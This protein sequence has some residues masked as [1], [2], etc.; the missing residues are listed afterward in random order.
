MKE[1]LYVKLART[2][3]AYQRCVKEGK[4]FQ[5]VHWTTIQDIMS[6][7]PSGSGIDSGT[8]F[9]DTRSNGDK[10]VFYTHY[11]H[12]NE[13]GY[14]DGWTDH[15][16]TVKPSL[17]FGFDLSISGKNRNDIK[18]YLHDVYHYWLNGEVS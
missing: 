8:T 11:H 7:A 2:L 14:Y 6:T 15:T 1:K 12:M 3:D 10:L 5:F 9:D 13:G 18:D 4:D 16:I 17:M